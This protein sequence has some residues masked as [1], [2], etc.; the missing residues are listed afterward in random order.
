MQAL[1]TTDDVAAFMQVDVITVRR[2][3]QRGE[4]AA[5][6]VG[7]EYRFTQDMIQAYLD[8]TYRPVTALPEMPLTD[9]VRTIV[10]WT[11]SEARTRGYGELTLLLLI[12]GLMRDQHGI[13]AQVLAKHGMTFSQGESG[14]VSQQSQAVHGEP[15]IGERA[16]R[17]LDR[18]H[19]VMRNRGHERLGTDDLLEA[20]LLEGDSEVMQFLERH[21]T[22]PQDCLST[23]NLTR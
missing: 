18:A 5:Y 17:T 4:L 16:A 3:I 22:S 2:L 11:M 6:R 14:L 21:Q 8:A 15:Q 13:A 23:L 9:R 1:L 20:I 7:N 19:T 12:L 10:A